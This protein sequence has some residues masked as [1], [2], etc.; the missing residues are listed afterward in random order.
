M[1][2][3]LQTLLVTLNLCFVVAL[4]QAAVAASILVIASDLGDFVWKQRFRAVLI[5]ELFRKAVFDG[6]ATFPA[7]PPPCK[8]SLQPSEMF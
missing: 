1:L 4:I 3:F 6:L 7:V 8:V 5:S 2:V